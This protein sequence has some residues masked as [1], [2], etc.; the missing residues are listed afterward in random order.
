MK[1]RV[2]STLLVSV[3]LLSACS[4]NIVIDYTGPIADWPNVTGAKGGGQFSP[5]T[6]IDKDNV[7]SL[8]I[9]WTY[10]PADI[11]GPGGHGEPAG[12]I[13]D[14]TAHASISVSVTPIIAGD[15][16]LLCSPQHRVIAL[17]PETGKEFWSYDPKMDRV[18]QTH[19]CRG[20]ASWSNSE[21]ISGQACQQQVFSMSGDGRLIGLDIETGRPCADFGEG[22]TLNLTRDLG[23]VKRAEYYQTSPPLVIGDL[24]VAG[25]GVRDGFRTDTAGGVI[26]A[27]DAR[28]GKLVWAWD[29]VAPE[30]PA[31]T[32]EDVAQGRTFTRGTPNAWTFLS[33]DIENNLIFVPTG[34]PGVDFFRGKPR[35]RFNYYGSSVVALKAETGEVVW[36]FQTVHHDI[37]DYDVGAQQPVLYEHQGKI[38][39]IAVATKPGHIFLLNRLTGGPLFAIEE[40]SV[41]DSDVPG[42]WT[43][44]TQPFPTLPEPVGGTALTGKDLMKYPWAS[45]GCSERFAE[46]RSGPLFTPPSLQ[47]TLVNPGIGGGFNWGGMAISPATGT[48]VSTYLKI[49]FSVKLVPREDNRTPEEDNDP[50]DW[51]SFPQYGT[52]YRLATSPF[53]SDRGVP[54]IKPPWGMMLAIDLSSGET[55]WEIPIGNL[56]T[57]VPLIG[58]WLNVGTPV[59]GGPMQ[60][61]SGLAFVAATTDEYFRAFDA[62]TGRELWAQQLPF[63][64]HA[65]PMTYRLSKQSKQFVVIASGGSNVMDKHQGDTLVAFALP[66]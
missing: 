24:I 34:N 3:F 20:V 42:E 64:A 58:R 38:P 59:S 18:V 30:M 11:K 43:S 57:F 33:A 32:A 40:R 60:T 29:P 12:N 52:P 63:S 4:D 50:V 31:V 10:S 45:K 61:A 26:R 35:D 22:G 44:P 53:L 9:A 19:T 25:S 23:P 1:Q 65:I 47:G 15:K 21:R 27:F 48:L 28:S 54:C 7:D 41:P 2:V 49:P 17:D 36:H 39:A 14:A 62:Q 51:Q 16:M 56:N 46:L 8:E 6:Q 13:E 5:L 66:N 37:W 55:L